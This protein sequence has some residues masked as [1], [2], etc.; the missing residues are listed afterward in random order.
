MTRLRRRSGGLDAAKAPDALLHPPLSATLALMVLSPPLNRFYEGLIFVLALI[1]GCIKQQAT[2]PCEAVE[3]PRP[4][5]GTHTFAEAKARQPEIYSLLQTPMLSH[6]KNP[7]LG[8]NIHVTENDE[9]VVYSSFLGEGRMTSS[10][11]EKLLDEYLNLIEG[12]PLGVLITSECDPKKS[13]SI[14]LL[15]K[16]LF[17]PS[18]QVF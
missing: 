3:L 16:L 15:I 12:N 5:S 18:V 6:W 7:C 1:T 11:V 13:S 4:N 9:L 10:N 2:P 17:K 8:F 14:P